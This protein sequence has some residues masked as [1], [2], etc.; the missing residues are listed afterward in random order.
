[1]LVKL[2]LSSSSVRNLQVTFQKAILSSGFTLAIAY[3]GLHI[4]I[5]FI[6]WDVLEQAL[7]KGVYNS[8]ALS[9]KVV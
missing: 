3:Q 4:C 7:T 8:S 6:K 9:L 2:F 5:F 1:M